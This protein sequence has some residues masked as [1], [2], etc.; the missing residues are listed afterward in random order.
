LTETLLEALRLISDQ[1]R[2]A[3]AWR[4]PLNR[5]GTTDDIANMVEFFTFPQSKLDYR[6]NYAWGW[7]NFYFESLK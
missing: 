3:N 2:Q 5:I 1:K 7:W 6:T 4:H